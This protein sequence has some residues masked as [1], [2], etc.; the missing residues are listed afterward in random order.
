[1]DATPPRVCLNLCLSSGYITDKNSFP[2]SYVG[3]EEG[4]G[5]TGMA[6]PSRE[7][8]LELLLFV[9]N[10]RVVAQER[11]QQARKDVS[12]F[13]GFWNYIIHMVCIYTYGVGYD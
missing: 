4:G 9:Y 8:L 6:Q 2:L 10:N 1:M 3:G 13:W 12:F 11:A 5:G 7:H